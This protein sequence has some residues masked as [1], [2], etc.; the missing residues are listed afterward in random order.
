MAQAV[1]TD[2]RYV[3]VWLGASPTAPGAVKLCAMDR[4]AF[5]Q[6][7]NTNDVVVPDCDDP[8]V[9][10]AVKRTPISKSAEIS[11]TGY[12]ESAHYEDLRTFFAASSAQDVCFEIMAPDP[13]P[14]WWSGKFLMNQFQTIGNNPDG[15]ITCDLGFQSDGPWTWTDAP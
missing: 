9:V 15:Y 12:Y 8:T 7:L 11:A 3:R 13:N 14:G 4:K 1:L 5:N 10:S 6:T 2:A